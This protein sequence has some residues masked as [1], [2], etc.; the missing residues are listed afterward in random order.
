MM[1]D[2]A[3]YVRFLFYMLMYVIGYKCIKLVLMYDLYI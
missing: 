2:F 1:Y 3:N